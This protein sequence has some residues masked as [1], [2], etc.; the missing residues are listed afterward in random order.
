M[1]CERCGEYRE[2]VFSHAPLHDVD[3]KQRPKLSRWIRNQNRLGS[4]PTIEEND[5]RRLA[6]APPMRFSEK[7]DRL[8]LYMVRETRLFG[9]HIH[10]TVPLEVEAMLETFENEEILF[11]ARYLE[12]RGWA[13]EAGNLVFQ[14]TGAGFARAEELQLQPSSRQGFVAMWFDRPLDD[15]WERGFSVGI[16]KAGYEAQRIDLKEHANKICDEIVAEIRRSRFVVADFTKHRGGVYFEAG[17][18]QGLGLP[19]I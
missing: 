11:V 6:S 18:A 19:V 2:T 9:Q 14:V 13:L 1:V 16:R 4:V 15:A 3:E 5:V 12:Q 8:L 7:A 17:F 10:V